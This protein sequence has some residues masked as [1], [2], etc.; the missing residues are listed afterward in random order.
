[1]VFSTLHQ[2]LLTDYRSNLLMINSKN[3]PLFS[4]PVGGKSTEKVY[5]I[6]Y[7]EIKDKIV[8]GN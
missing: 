2:C 1:M 5:G 7:D 8:V 6:C 4:L 3:I